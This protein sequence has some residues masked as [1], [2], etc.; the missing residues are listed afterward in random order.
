MTIGKTKPAGDCIR[1]LMSTRS[2]TWISV[3]TCTFHSGVTLAKLLLGY[4]VGSV[5]TSQM[6]SQNSLPAKLDHPLYRN[7]PLR[8]AIGMPA[9]AVRRKRRESRIRRCTMKGVTRCSRQHV[10]PV[11]V[12]SDII[13]SAFEASCATCR[14]KSVWLL[15]R[16][17]LGEPEKDRGGD[18][19]LTPASPSSMRKSVSRSSMSLRMPCNALKDLFSSLVLSS[20]LV[21]SPASLPKKHRDRQWLSEGT[22]ADT[23]Q[24]HPTR[25]SKRVQMARAIMSMSYP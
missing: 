7:R 14:T 6:R 20:S 23:I 11:P 15:S 21:A 13:S 16:K 2:T 24:G 8:T 1:T 10:I 9:R 4:L 12:G 22:V 3:H 17:L 19:A 5:M 18:C 25:E